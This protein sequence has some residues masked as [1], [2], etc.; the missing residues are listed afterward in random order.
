LLQM[1]DETVA[2]VALEKLMCVEVTA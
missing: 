1:G 2:I